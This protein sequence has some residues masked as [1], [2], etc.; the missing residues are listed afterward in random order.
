[1]S[2]FSVTPAIIAKHGT[3]RFDAPNTRVMRGWYWLAI[4]RPSHAERSPLPCIRAAHVIRSGERMSKATTFPPI[5]RWT[6]QAGQSYQRA[7]GFLSTHRQG[8]SLARLE[9]Q[10]PAAVA[11][12]SAEAIA[13]AA[14]AGR[15]ATARRADLRLSPGPEIC[16]MPRGIGRRDGSVRA[17]TQH[18]QATTGRAGA[19]PRGRALTMS[20]AM[21]SGA[22]LTRESSTN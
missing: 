19:A 8:Q 10:V 21:V 13:A 16:S 7:G 5:R 15:R 14:P 12:Q 1:M 18:R 17:R 6:R 3:S 20:M 9:G 11:V 2:P 22:G 4:S